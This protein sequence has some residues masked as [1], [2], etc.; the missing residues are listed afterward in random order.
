MKGARVIVVLYIVALASPA[1]AQGIV[2]DV[3]SGSLIKP[4]PGVYA[5][6]ELHDKTT[7]RKFFVRQAIVG[8]E[9]VER[10][11][12]YWLETEIIPEEGFP[13]I[14]KMLI[15]GPASDP[16]NVHK[17][18]IKEGAEPPIAV[19]VEVSDESSASKTKE[20]R[21]SSGKEKVATPMGEIMAERIIITRESDG[22]AT[23]ES[24]VQIWVNDDVRPMGIVKMVS[25]SG[26][27]MLQRHG[28]GGPESESAMD[29]ITPKTTTSASGDLEVRVEGG[30]VVSPPPA[31]EQQ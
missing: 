17:I 9:K 3:L 22:Q 7:G 14:Y 8:K 4:E 27:M 10:K 16:R 26:E 23:G 15:T 13:A 25:D 24:P 31:E 5:W 1:V 6:Y 2:G 12:G 28:K 18:F 21:K 11:D 29:R 30:V 20:T 19:P